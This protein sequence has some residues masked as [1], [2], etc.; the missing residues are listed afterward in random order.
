MKQTL[1]ILILLALSAPM[2]GAMQGKAF[3][4]R[5]GGASAWTVQFTDA[6]AKNKIV[7][8]I[9]DSFG[10]EPRQGDPDALTK[11]QFAMRQIQHMIAQTVREGRRRARDKNI[12]PV[13]ETDIP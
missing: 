3:D 5:N 8:D 2:L 13:D 4:V 11:N 1:F 6:A 9:C 12:Q 10:Y 7:D